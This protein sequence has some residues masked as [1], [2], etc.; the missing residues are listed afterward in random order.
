[1]ADFWKMGSIVPEEKNNTGVSLILVNSEKGE[2]LLK[3]SGNTLALKKLDTD[4]ASYNLKKRTYSKDYMNLR[5]EYLSVCEKQ[6]L[7]E[8]M[9]LINS[10][11]KVQRML[12]K[13][14]YTLKGLAVRFK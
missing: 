5:K 1:M 12:T 8:A 10:S 4:V 13:L 9:K 7:E 11:S 3:N 14:K 2:Q 6:G